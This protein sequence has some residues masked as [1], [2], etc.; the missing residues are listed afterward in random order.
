MRLRRALAAALVILAIGSAARLRPEQAV[1]GADPS[2]SLNGRADVPAPVMSALRRG[3]FD[4][5]SDATR[6]PWYARLPVASQLIARDVTQARGQLN[7]SRWAQY[8]PFDRADMLDKMCQLPAS[9]KMPPWQY[10][11]MHPDARLSATDIAALCAWTR[12]EAARLG[13]GER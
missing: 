7:L 10:R 2:V 8:N 4:C 1:A 11:L 12:D 5:H 13:E 6:W 9:G 3:C